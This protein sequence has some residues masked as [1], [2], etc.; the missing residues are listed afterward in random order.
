MVLSTLSNEFV[1]V[2]VFTIGLGFQRFVQKSK[3]YT[4]IENGTIGLSIS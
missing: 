1:Y 2:S 4:L 3:S